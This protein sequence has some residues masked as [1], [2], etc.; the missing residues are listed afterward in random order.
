MALWVPMEH[1]DSLIGQKSF[2]DSVAKRSRVIEKS[3]GNVIDSKAIL[4][5]WGFG[6][7]D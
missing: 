7:E 5:G 6:G 2:L 1:C 3:L 4:L